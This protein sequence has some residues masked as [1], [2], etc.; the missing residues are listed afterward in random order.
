MMSCM[1]KAVHLGF[2]S[3]AA[4]DVPMVPN[5]AEFVAIYDERTGE[6]THLYYPEFDITLPILYN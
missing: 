1:N 3:P 5:G 6:P 2:A 4:G